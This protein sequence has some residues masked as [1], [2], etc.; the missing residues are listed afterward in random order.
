MSTVSVILPA[1]NQGDYLRE[2]IQSVL[3]Q[4]HPDFEII[5][6][7]DGSTDHT[8]EVVHE[9]SD[10][11]V[12]Y[13]YQEN[14]GLSGARN[15]GIRHA[16]G[17]YLSYLNSDDQFL[18]R[19]LEYLV[20][21]IEKKPQIGFVAGQ[22]IP[23]D[24]HGNQIGK[25][26]DKPIP[27]DPVQLLIGNP[28]HVGSVLLHRQW[29]EKAGFFDE[30]L[31]SYEDW[32]MWLRLVNLGCKTGWVPKPVSLYRFHTQQMTRNS[33]QMTEATFTVLNKFF[34]DPDLSEK[35][36]ATKDK[37][38]SSANLR[39]TASFYSTEDYAQA[40]E[41]LL[42]AIELNSDWLSGDAEPLAQKFTAFAD[43]PKHA[44]PLAFLERIYH[45]LPDGMD[46]LKDHRKEYLGQA[47]IQFAFEA[48]QN[49]D[50]ETAQRFILRALR[51]QPGS[52]SNRGVLS[53]LIRTVL[54]RSRPVEF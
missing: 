25:I 43:S 19:K 20:E 26:Y 40:G 27:E 52:I 1:Y 3:V 21:E 12:R 29:Q 41:H 34:E 2:A 48:Y 15:T 45:N 22:A 4:T 13:I 53:I 9:F 39:A 46:G 47:A 16:S 44:D 42:K 50:M 18:P 33:L 49:G 8:C 38:Y 7:D 11:R 51:Y 10:E 32:D 23:I 6:V 5:I 54:R 17:V 35:W 28:L 37:A 31:R 30:T 14:R 24:E 36:L